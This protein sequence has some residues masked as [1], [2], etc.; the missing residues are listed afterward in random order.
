[1]RQL[2]FSGKIKRNKGLFHNMS[3]PG[4]REL[5]S[6]PADWPE[7]LIPGSLNIRIDLGLLP[8]VFSAIG[9][10]KNMK[11]F[12]SGDF[13]PEFEISHDKLMGNSLLPTADQPRKGT[14]QIWRANLAT[15]AG[16][17]VKCWMLRRI[18]S[19]IGAQIELV[20]EHHLRTLLGLEDGTPVNVTI[21]EGSFA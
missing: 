10:G 2:E 4:R 13:R 6:A 5:A 18:G 9:S 7:T 12:D 21:Y 3:I 1:M 17:D 19:S 20:S 14:A 16:T 11:E 15:A 8:D